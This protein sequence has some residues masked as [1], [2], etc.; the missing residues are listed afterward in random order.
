MQHHQRGMTTLGFIILMVFIG[1]FIYGGIRLTPAY[2]EYFEVSKALNGLQAEAAG[3]YSAASLRSTLEK[4]FD[5][6]DVTGLDAKD[7][8]IHHEDEGWVVHA[9]WDVREPFLG[10]VSFLVHFDTSVTLKGA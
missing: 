4:H 3:V 5:I 2:V 1:L 6:D 9:V 10:N 8:D 7:V